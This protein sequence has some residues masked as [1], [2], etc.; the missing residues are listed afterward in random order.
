MAETIQL[1]VVTPDGTKLS[2]Q[3]DELTAPSVD[4]EFG[5]L[6]GHR[7]MLA[8]LKTGIVR[9]AIGPEQK[10][11]AVGP[12]FVQ[13]S[14]DRAILLTDRFIEKAQVDPVRAR[15]ELKETDEAL[16]RF[17][18]DPESA[19][20]ARLILRAAWAAAQLELYGDPPPPTIRSFEH[21]FRLV[22]EESYRPEEG[23][24]HGN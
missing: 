23:H 17:D 8:A 24:G 11:V 20:L 4:G 7:P 21:E 2:T 5:V 15:L 1:E 18:G 16:D 3:V 14:D 10:E 22:S 9:F 13:V 19:E 12:G 6:P